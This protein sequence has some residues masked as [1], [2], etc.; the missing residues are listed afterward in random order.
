LYKKLRL[1]PGQRKNR[2]KAKTVDKHAEVIEK[3]LYKCI[4]EGLMHVAAWYIT[5][6]P[7][8]L[9]FMKFGE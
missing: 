7:D 4:S 1:I 9:K 3:P 2:N 8:H 6:L 5:G